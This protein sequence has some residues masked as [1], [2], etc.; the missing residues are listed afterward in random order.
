V[1]QRALGWPWVNFQRYI[2]TWI[3]SIM[4]DVVSKSES[5]RIS[6]PNPLSNPSLQV[7]Q[8]SLMQGD[9]TTHPI[10]RMME[11][12]NR[13]L[14]DMENAVR[15]EDPSP[16]FNLGYWEYCRASALA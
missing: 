13:A 5:S 14:R 12:A 6:C 10:S 11:F 3:M 16:G 1:A 15:P 8:I 4:V 7:C 9:L 2:Y